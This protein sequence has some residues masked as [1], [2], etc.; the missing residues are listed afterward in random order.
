MKPT[1]AC[2]VG[3][4]MLVLLAGCQG[5]VDESGARENKGDIEAS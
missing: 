3:F 2:L 1:V 5:S 4:L